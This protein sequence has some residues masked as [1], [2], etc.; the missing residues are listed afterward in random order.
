T[1]VPGPLTAP[2]A[3][4]VCALPDGTVL[5]STAF[6]GQASVFGPH[7]ALP[8]V[9]GAHSF[10]VAS[11]TVFVPAS[12]PETADLIRSF[13]YTVVTADVAGFARLGVL[14]GSLAALS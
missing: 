12:A 11:T 13:G 10:S 6:D 7:L 3:S 14:P 5:V 4:L 8:E 9:T 1:A 2:L